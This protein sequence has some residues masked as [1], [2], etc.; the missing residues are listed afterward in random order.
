MGND[1]DDF[2]SGYGNIYRT[3]TQD[4]NDTLDGGAGADELL[5]GMGDDSLLGGDGD[6]TLNG[7]RGH[8]VLDGGSGRDSLI[9]GRGNDTLTGG[10]GSDT[11]TGGLGSDVFVFSD[12]SYIDLIRDFDA[13]NNVDKIDLSGVTGFDDIDDILGIG[14][15]AR[16][17][18]NNSVWLDFGNSNRVLL[19]GVKLSH[20]D[21]ADFIF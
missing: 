1:G 12:E 3:T 8:D 10:T 16:D 15:A 4:G 6:D 14:G 19:G 2:L 5:G 17:T 20:L 7:Q 13:K 18:G 9:G 11:M 21:E